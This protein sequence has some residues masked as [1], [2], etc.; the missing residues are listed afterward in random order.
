M[1]RKSKLSA[2]EKGKIDAL[3]AQGVSFREIARQLGRSD[4]VVRNYCSNPQQYGSKSSPGRP[5]KLSPR[6]KRDIIR[7]ASNSTKSITQIRHESGVSASK[8]TILRVLHND[9]HIVRA[10]MMPV[11]LLKDRHKVARLEFARENMNRA[12]NLV[13]N[14]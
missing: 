6:Q 9:P 8:S 2:Y 13:R 12:W 1:G 10:K 3:R 11:P 4:H 7:L 5:K 14:L